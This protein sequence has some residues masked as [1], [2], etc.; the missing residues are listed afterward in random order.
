[1]SDIGT[2]R[3]GNAS[4]VFPLPAIDV[5]FVPSSCSRRVVARYH[6]HANIVQLANNSIQ[7]LNRLS[8]SFSSSLFS[9]STFSHD[10]LRTS[11]PEARHPLSLSQSRLQSH[12]YSCASRFYRR[13][14]HTSG[15]QCVDSLS[16]STHTHTSAYA[17]PSFSYSSLKHAALPVVASRISLPS[18]TGSVKLVDYLPPHLRSTYLSPDTLVR[19]THEQAHSPRPVFYTS[20]HEYVVLI[21]RMIAIDM[22]SFTLTPRVVNGV[23][24]VEKDA[25]VDRLIID[26]RPANAVFV[27]PP[28]VQLPTPDL[29][30]N[31]SVQHDRPLYVAKVDLDNFYHRLRLPDWMRDFFALPPVRAGD[32]GMSSTFGEETLIFPRCNT[33]PMGWS[34]SVYVA[35]AVHEHILDTRTSLHSHDRITSTHDLRVDRARHQVYIDDLI[36]YGHDPAVLASLQDEYVD[37]VT[38]AGLV[39]KLSKLVRPCCTGVD[40]VGV[41]VDGVSGEVGVAVPKL[42]QLCADTA[43]LIHARV[44]TGIQL[45]Q[46]VGKWT[47]AALANRPALS[48]FSAVYRFIE[49]AGSRTFILWPSVTR[50]L[51]T[52]A[53][54][55]PLLFSSLRQRW[56]NRVVASDASELGLGVTATATMPVSA[57]TLMNVMDNCVN[58]PHRVI[59]SSRWQHD[60]HINVLEVRAVN[61]AVRWVLSFPHSLATHLIILCDSMV[62]C[63]AI[64]KGRSSSPL[65]LPRLRS[66]AALLLASAL[67]LHLVW[68]PSCLNPADAPSRLL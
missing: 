65:L 2:T 9:S 17:D 57:S 7:S 61:T 23:F 36:L 25:D 12:I 20:Q 4:S 37:V 19:P 50:E 32:V 43:S 30:C 27:E 52:M 33:L 34:H 67:R 41:N 53:G 64:S 51:M 3:A 1:M 15:S 38:I 10:S 47:W 39:V 54:V 8:H 56:F 68:L 24:A 48:I 21:R 35:Q 13:R 49:R 28:S 26:A 14:G 45:S 46:L 18:S 60:E 31:L 62:A 22:V 29:I 66:L 42:L 44:C 40:C 55:A 16:S 5:P 63:C 59:V 58:V 11:Q 6:D